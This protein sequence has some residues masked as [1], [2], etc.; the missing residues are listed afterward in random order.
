MRGADAPSS[1]GARLEPQG[2]AAPPLQGGDWRDKFANFASI[3]KLALGLNVFI[4][5]VN[6]FKGKTNPHS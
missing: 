6:Y 4:S 5:A 1:C 2:F 3:S